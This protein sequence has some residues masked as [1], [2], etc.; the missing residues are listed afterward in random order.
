MDEIY[1][2]WVIPHMAKEITKGAKFLATLSADELISIS[3]A[4]VTSGV[5]SK[6]KEMM[7]DGK[8]PTQEEVEVI[9]EITRE[10]FLKGGEKRFLELLKDEMS[11][12][13]LGVTTN[14]AGK[15]KNLAQLTDKM[16]NVLRQFIGTP[17]IRQDPEMVKLLNTIL[18][19]SGLSP[20]LFG[21]RLSPIQP[22]GSASTEGLKQLG[23]AAKETV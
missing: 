4:V 8:L 2:D 21:P 19:S 14:I 15:Q 5:N 6:I 13:K 7:L 12:E 16:V 22:K 9:R 10:N 23:A 17:E 1:R 18:E 11:E 3:N 20:I